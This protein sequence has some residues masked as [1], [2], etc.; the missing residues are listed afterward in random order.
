MSAKNRIRAVAML[1][2]LGVWGQA[3]ADCHAADFTV[4]KIASVAG[5]V[6]T[7]AANLKALQDAPD[8]HSSDS[9][10][11]ALAAQVTDRSASEALSFSGYLVIYGRLQ[12]ADDMNA[13]DNFVG[14]MAPVLGQDLKRYA[15]F[16]TVV[17]SGSPR[18]NAE[19]REARD[20]VRKLQGL[21]A[22]ATG[23]SQQ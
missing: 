23:S 10:L 8:L 13:T 20:Q 4:D 2:L 3:S 18:F 19:I 15:D 21:F 12:H 9:G 5:G 7:A 17:A 22:C 6:N 14:S 11:L 1:L 16:L